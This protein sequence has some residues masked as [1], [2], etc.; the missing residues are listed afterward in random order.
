MLSI[1][2]FCKIKFNC[3]TFSNS[4]GDIAILCTLLSKAIRFLPVNFLFDNKTLIVLLENL[5]S[6]L[7]VNFNWNDFIWEF[8]ISIYLKSEYVSFALESSLKKESAIENVSAKSVGLCPK[9]IYSFRIKLFYFILDDASQGIY[10][11][12]SKIEICFFTAR[13]LQ[14]QRMLCCGEC[15]HDVFTCIV[16]CCTWTV[17]LAKSIVPRIT[18]RK[19]WHSYI[20][21]LFLTKMQI[22]FSICFHRGSLNVIGD[23]FRF[24]RSKLKSR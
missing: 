9:H 2:N 13:I 16:Y 22:K 14:N 12:M 11:Y 1:S 23:K 6:S 18:W 5:F 17:T 15:F 24:V 3:F 19:L 21:K 4:S 8:K 7:S 20:S 10:M